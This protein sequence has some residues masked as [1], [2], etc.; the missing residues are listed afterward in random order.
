MRKRRYEILL[1]LTHADGRPVS[2]K[3]FAQ[4]RDDLIAHSERLTLLPQVVLSIWVHEGTRYEGESRHLLVDVDD[5]PE[6]E[7]FF[8]SFKATLME[9]FEQIEIYLISYPID[10]V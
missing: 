9:R 3:K 4:T 5:T 6:N 10:R 1:P 7:Q 2:A 8:A